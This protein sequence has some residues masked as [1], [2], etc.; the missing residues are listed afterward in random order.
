[1]DK[2]YECVITELNRLQEDNPE[3]TKVVL[4][5]ELDK[6]ATVLSGS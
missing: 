2:A 1:M 4:R 5:H 3:I 6:A